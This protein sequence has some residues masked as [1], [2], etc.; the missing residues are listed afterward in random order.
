MRNYFVLVIT[1]LILNPFW[2][3]KFPLLE[4]GYSI[5]KCK[6]FNLEEFDFPRWQSL[7]SILIIGILVGLN[8]AL[9][10]DTILLIHMPL[11]LMLLLGIAVTCFVFLCFLLIIRYWLLSIKFEIA[12]RLLFNWLVATA[13]FGQIFCMGLMGIQ[14]PNWLVILIVF[15]SLWVYATSLRHLINHKVASYKKQ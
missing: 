14:S 8:F 10:G 9:Y 1:L 7:L 4:L 15:Y 2:R 12:D 5:F 13:L 6:K 11:P 3:H